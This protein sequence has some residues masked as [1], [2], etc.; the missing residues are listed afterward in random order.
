[1]SRAGLFWLDR[2]FVH[3]HEISV[4]PQVV[5]LGS[6][7]KDLATHPDVGCCEITRL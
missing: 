2:N 3:M 1:L 7:W 6:V 4:K 5:G